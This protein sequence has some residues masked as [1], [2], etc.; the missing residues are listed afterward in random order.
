[1]S[2]P[3]L[4]TVTFEETGEERKVTRR[5]K[6]CLSVRPLWGTFGVVSKNGIE[7]VGGDYG[8]TACGKDAT[9]DTWWWPL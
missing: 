7:H 5:C 4:S 1:M 3:T 8:I 2:T 9:G 6:R